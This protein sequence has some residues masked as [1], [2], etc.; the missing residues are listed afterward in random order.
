MESLKEFIKRHEGF[1]NTVY[2]DPIGLPTLGVGHLLSK[3]ELSYLIVGDLIPSEVV[4][5]FLT[6]DLFKTEK[7]VLGLV[8]PVLKDYQHKA[9]TSFAFNVGI[10][11]LR[12]STLL[13]KVNEKN[14]TAAADEFLKWIYMGNP[15]KILPG[16]VKRR[17]EE[18]LMFLGLDWTIE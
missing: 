2:R 3:D 7:Q 9:L 17:K 8:F 15:P 18:R 14:F 1:K 16:L 11:N 10:S 6:I 13:K 4:E 12:R 5:A